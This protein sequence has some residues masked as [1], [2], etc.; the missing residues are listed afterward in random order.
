MDLELFMPSQDTVLVV[1]IVPSRK[2]QRCDLKDQTL[3]VEQLSRDSPS[4][5]SR[6]TTLPEAILIFWASQCRAFAGPRGTC[7]PLHSRSV[8]HRFSFLLSC[9]TRFFEMSNCSMGPCAR[10]EGLPVELSIVRLHVS[11]GSGRKYTS[12]HASRRRDAESPRTGKT[13]GLVPSF[14]GLGHIRCHSTIGQ[15]WN[16]DVRSG[17]ERTW[18]GERGRLGEAEERKRKGVHEGRYS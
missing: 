18:K 17:F 5:T 15:H 6:Y 3:S 9:V 10:D 8:L 13:A 14:S 2:L 4:K 7:V 16:K 1:G 11:D 12:F